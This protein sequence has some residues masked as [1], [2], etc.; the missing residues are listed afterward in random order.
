MSVCSTSKSNTNAHD[1]A[2]TYAIKAMQLSL[3]CTNKN[4]YEQTD[5]NVQDPDL[6][7]P[8]TDQEIAAVIGVFYQE[9]LVATD[10]NEQDLARTNTHTHTL[11]QIEAVQLSSEC[12]IKTLE[13][14]L[15]GTK[16][17]LAGF[18]ASFKADKASWGAELE[19]S[20]YEVCARMVPSALCWCEHVCVRLHTCCYC[21]M[22]TCDLCVFLVI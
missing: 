14:E 11:T 4:A 22:C 3:E 6:T 5:A 9:R 7:P 1:P 15:A 16:S 19:G 13:A 8:H 18:E 21:Y 12:A 2:H 20:K 17:S 10:T